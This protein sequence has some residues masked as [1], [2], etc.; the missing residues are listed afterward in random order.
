VVEQILRIVLDALTALPV[1]RIA[2]QLFARRRTGYAMVV[3]GTGA[4][5]QQAQARAT[6]R[7]RNV[8]IPGLR[9]RN[10][11]GDRLPAGAGARLA[12]RGWLT[13]LGLAA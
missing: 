12:R 2:V 4:T 13:P 3:T 9:W 7:A 8:I 1:Y 10:A 5:V 6:A 11:I